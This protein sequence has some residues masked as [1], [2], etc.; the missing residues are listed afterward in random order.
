MKKFKHMSI[1]LI[2]ISILFI[3]FT[4]ES[5]DTESNSTDSKQ[6]TQQE[7]TLANANDRIGLPAITNFYEKKIMKEIMEECDK[8]NL[9]NYA[10]VQSQMTGKFVYLGQCMGYPIPYGTE[11][12]NPERIADSY[13][14]GYAILPQ[15]DPNGLFKPQDVSA[16]WLIMIDPKT[17]NK[18]VQYCEPNIFVSPFKLEKWQLESGGYPKNY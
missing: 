13:Q 4:A 10:Y 12:T 3:M 1:I 17:G 16:T 18:H 8:A 11:Y 2:A 9:I 5:C 14:S 15:A 6:S 7:Q